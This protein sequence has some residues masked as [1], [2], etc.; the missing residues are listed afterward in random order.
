MDEL[1]LRQKYQKSLLSIKY[2][3]KYILPQGILYKVRFKLIYIGS[4]PESLTVIVSD[5]LG[6]ANV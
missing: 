5:L 4:S 6:K 1:H 3:I 2:I